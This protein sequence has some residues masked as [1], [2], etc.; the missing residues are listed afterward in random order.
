MKD[1]PCTFTGYLRGDEL[2][3]IY[4]SSDV[5]VF[6]STTDTFGNVVLEAQA[7]GLPVIVTDE[8]GP[9][10]NMIENKTGLIVEGNDTDSLVKAMRFL[11]IDPDRVQKMGKKRPSIYGRQIFRKRFQGNME[12]L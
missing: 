8:G 6:P 7:S 12:A 2:A 3:S 1:L 4:A 9:R 5:F 10:E 11:A